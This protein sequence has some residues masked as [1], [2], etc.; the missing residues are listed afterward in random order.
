MDLI[1]IFMATGILATVGTL[2]AAFSDRGALRKSGTNGLSRYIVRSD[3]RSESLRLIKHL[4][5]TAL[6]FYCVEILN[7]YVLMPTGAEALRLVVY[8]LLIVSGLMA[9]NSGLDLYSRHFSKHGPRL[10]GKHP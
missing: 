4:I 5:V 9:L 8:G 1:L 7:Q 2:M 10:R 6:S 3:I